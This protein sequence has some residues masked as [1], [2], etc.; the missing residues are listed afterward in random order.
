MVGQPPHGVGRHVC[1]GGGVRPG[2]TWA[3]PHQLHSPSSA[4]AA[5][6]TLLQDAGDTRLQRKAEMWWGGPTQ[7]GCRDPPQPRVSAP[8]SPINSAPVCHS[9]TWQP[10]LGEGQSL[11]PLPTRPTPTGTSPEASSPPRCAPHCSQRK[12]NHP[13]S[14]FF[15]VGWTPSGA[16]SHDPRPRAAL[17]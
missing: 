16:P 2:G 10:A 17:S 6:G 12:P 5:L 7:V 15:K 14:F 1:R 11:G 3:G 13:S 4:G 9:V 8:G